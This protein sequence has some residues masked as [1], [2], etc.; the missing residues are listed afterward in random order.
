MPSGMKYQYPVVCVEV[1]SVP[2]LNVVRA[3]AVAMTF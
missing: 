1:P 2:S 3:S